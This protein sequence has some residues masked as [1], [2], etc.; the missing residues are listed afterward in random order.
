MK[1]MLIYILLFFSINSFCQTGT[2]K[3]IVRDGIDNIPSKF[4]TIGLFQ[5]NEL[6]IGTIS[7][8]TGHFEID[9][10]SAGKYNLEFS[11]VGYQKHAISEIHVFSESKIFLE[12]KYP[13]PFGN[14]KSKKICPFGHRNNI[15]PIV[16]G[17]PTDKT[18]KKASKGKC[19]L[20]GCIAT[21]CD[22]KWY[23]KDH[24]IRF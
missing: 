24:K 13:C 17:L 1:R 20:G 5:N 12:A 14:N 16:Y 6:I 15:V 18:L 7:D 9:S 2:I 19:V 23:C 4:M 22:P 10:I 8:S 11:F 3:G 21:E